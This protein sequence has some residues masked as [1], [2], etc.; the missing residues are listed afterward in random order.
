MT[1]EKRYTV[2]V[3]GIEITDSLLTYQEAL[4]LA[5]EWRNRGYNDVVIDEY[6]RV[7]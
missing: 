7:D 2:W 5:D 3:G 6:D 4:E 1:I